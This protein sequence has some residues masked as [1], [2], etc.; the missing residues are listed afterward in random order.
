M[1]FYH[2]NINLVAEN[3]VFRHTPKLLGLFI[4]AEI[5]F[6]TTQ[7]TYEPTLYDAIYA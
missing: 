3:G 6:M 2:F 4:M 1:I 5:I 7:I